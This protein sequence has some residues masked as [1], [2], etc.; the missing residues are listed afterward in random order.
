VRVSGIKGSPATDS[1][2]VSCSYGDGYA[3]SGSMVYTWPDALGKAR[4]AGELALE[5][6]KALGFEFDAALVETVGHD[7][8]HRDIARQT[9]DGR[10]DE[11]QLRISV[12]GRDRAQM[13]RFGRDIVP[14]VL[15]GPPGATGF[16]G[17]R[18]RPS[19]V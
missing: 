1:Y 5:R 15:T 10:P 11:V 3:L 19:E 17:G 7:A 2:K 16:A 13:E 12:R 18:P 14:L 8:C 4:R 6:A 9:S